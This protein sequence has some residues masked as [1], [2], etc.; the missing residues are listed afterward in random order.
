MNF[1]SALMNLLLKAITQPFQAYNIKETLVIP[2][3]LILGLIM[4]II[5]TSLIAGLFIWEG[6]VN[7]LH[8]VLGFLVLLFIF[9]MTVAIAFLVGVTLLGHQWRMVGVL[10]ATNFEGAV[11]HWADSEWKKHFQVGVHLLGYLG[12]ILLLLF[13]LQ[14]FLAILTGYHAQAQL[15]DTPIIGD[16]QLVSY[17]DPV[18]VYPA[19][20]T[21]YFW[22]ILMTSLLFILIGPFLLGPVFYVAHD[23]RLSLLIANLGAAWRW[24]LSR[25]IQVC[26]T[27]LFCQFCL[28]FVVFVLAACC[29]V[30]VVGL[31]VVPF[32]FIGAIVIT[33]SLLTC[34][35]SV[36]PCLVGASIGNIQPDNPLIG[37]SPE[38]L[39]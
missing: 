11:P 23:P 33:N 32:L 30:T 7:P 24:T 6:V 2:V 35:F 5:I 15:L 28:G 34:A 10:Q 31:V 14:D 27:L 12:I 20:L 13:L 25:Y 38:R 29:M 16:F 26:G 39:G 17:I 8:G 36:P 21:S 18:E 1:G 3:G 37:T 22:M 4:T 19:L 9:P